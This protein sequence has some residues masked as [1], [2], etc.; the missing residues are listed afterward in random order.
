M[1]ESMLCL[2]GWQGPRADSNKDLQMRESFSRIIRTPGRN[3][4]PATNS[5]FGRG[6]AAPGASQAVLNM[7][8]DDTFQ[9]QEIL[10]S[11]MFAG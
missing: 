5:S 10:M 11:D 4:F 2:G 6:K 1:L 9:G 3:P 8:A 7:V